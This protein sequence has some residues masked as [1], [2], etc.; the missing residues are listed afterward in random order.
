MKKKQHLITFKLPAR[1]VKYYQIFFFVCFLFIYSSPAGIR[2]HFLTVK[3]V[4]CVYCVSKKMANVYYTLYRKVQ[5]YICNFVFVAYTRLIQYVSIKKKKNW[6]SRIHNTFPFVTNKINKT[7]FIV[8]TLKNIY[9][10]T[11]WYSLFE[12]KMYLFG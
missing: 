8:K 2:T 6:I 7:N 9:I 12:Y 5:N 1:Y 10:Q 11:V 3:V 4:K